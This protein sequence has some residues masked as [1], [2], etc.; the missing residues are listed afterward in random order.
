MKLDALRGVIPKENPVGW[1][2]EVDEA[3]RIST[4]DSR[5]EETY[6]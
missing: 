6:P 4:E 2:I 5:N 3:A 1:V